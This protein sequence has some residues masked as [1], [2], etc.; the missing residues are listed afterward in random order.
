MT[1]TAVINSV[2]PLNLLFPLQRV[3]CPQSRQSAKYR[4]VTHNFTNDDLTNGKSPIYYMHG[5]L[6][7]KIQY[8]GRLEKLKLIIV[9][10]G[11]LQ[12]KE[13]VGD[14][15]SLTDSIRNFK[16][17]LADAT[18]HKARVNQ[19]YLIVPFLQ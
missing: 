1:L 18:K 12:N 3:I 8:N 11:Y 7:G 2:V 5:C 10:R 13:L 17:F 15:W 9:V 6:Q 14:T 4:I 16:Y 19:L